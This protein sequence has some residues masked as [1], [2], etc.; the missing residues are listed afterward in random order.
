[1]NAIKNLWAQEPV[2]ITTLVGAVLGL[3]VTFGIDLP[4]G[5]AT[6]IDGVIVAIG[7]IIAR[8]QVSSPATVAALATPGA[9]TP[10]DSI[11]G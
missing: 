11:G 9:V 7:A 10:S 3:L 5:L 2:L 4:A 8:S 1:M 6:A